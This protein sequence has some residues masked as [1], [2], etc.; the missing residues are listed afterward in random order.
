MWR[1]LV[2]Q[3]IISNNPKALELVYKLVNNPETY[4]DDPV[5]YCQNIL[6]VNLWSKQIEIAEALIKYRKVMVRSSNAVGKSFLC[7]CLA[8]WFHQTHVPGICLVTA[9]TQRQ[10]SDITFKELRRLY[11]GPGIYPK[12]PRIQ[13]SHEHYVYGFTA[14]DATAYQGI[15]GEN[16]FIIFEECTGVSSEFWEAANGV[17]LGGTNTYFLAVCNPTDTSSEAYLQEQTGRW[18]T[19]SISALDHPNIKLELEGKA[20]LIP[21]AIR[22]KEL[23]DLI[24]QWCEPVVTEPD[25]NDFEFMGKWWRPGPIA[26]ARLLGRYPTQG[27]YSIFNEQD[28]NRSLNSIKESGEIVIGVDVA[29]FGNDNTCIHVING[30]SSVY[31]ESYNGRD[32]NYTANRI[33]QLADKFAGDQ[34]TKIKIH[35]DSTGIG[36]G[37]ADQKG[38]YNFIEINSSHRAN[39]EEAYPNKRSELLFTVGELMKKGLLS[40]ANLP[41]DQ[42]HELK[43]QALGITYKLDNKGR[44]VAEKKDDIKKRIGRSPDDLDAVALAYCGKSHLCDLGEYFDKLST[45][46]ITPVQYQ[47]ELSL[48]RNEE[49]MAAPVIT[50]YKHVRMIKTFGTYQ[51]YPL[52]RGVESPF[53]DYRSQHEAAYAVNVAHKLQGIPE[54]NKLNVILDKET[55]EKIEKQIKEILIK[56][57]IKLIEDKPKVKVEEK[58]VIPAPAG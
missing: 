34:S 50:E 18:H 35:V 54:P 12:N 1:D 6:K 38:A 53:T 22:L 47:K 17:L 44:R 55:S 14:N 29:R 25:L 9:P 21:A 43:R 19:I 49:Q 3:A 2:Q 37:L 4:H 46:I 27:S 32:T 31:H 58:K 33:K 23:N 56:R 24:E 39:N 15:H 26:D 30:Q 10:V 20:P 48:A 41:F 7:A 51:A 52:I 13:Q 57:R 42:Y 40:F 45:T 16:L 36:G 5:G 8:S 28:F 11:K